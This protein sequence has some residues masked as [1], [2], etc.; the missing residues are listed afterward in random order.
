MSTLNKQHLALRLRAAFGYSDRDARRTVRDVLVVL[1]DLLED[2][3]TD[4]SLILEHIGRFESRPTA[5]LSGRSLHR[6]QFKPSAPLASLFSR[7]PLPDDDPR[8][9][10]AKE[11]RAALAALPRPPWWLKPAEGEA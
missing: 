11:K 6:L 10:A 8:V 2:L 9:I 3:G 5:R 1:R 4:E 7:R